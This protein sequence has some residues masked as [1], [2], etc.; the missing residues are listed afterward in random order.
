PAVSSASV[1]GAVPA[2]N[3]AAVTA[4]LQRRSRAVLS[5]DRAA[6]LATVDPSDQAFLTGQETLF[7]NLAKIPLAAWHESLADTRPAA[8]ADDGW[9]AQVTLTYRL[10]GFDRRDLAYT[11]YLTFDRRGGM[12]WVVSGDGSAHGLR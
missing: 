12:G 3:P 1:A 7:D 2:P 11:Q 8:A 4:V 9:T 5:H 10:G 6:F